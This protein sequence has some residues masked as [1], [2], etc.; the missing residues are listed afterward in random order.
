M[1]LRDIEALCGLF[2]TGDRWC[3][4][5]VSACLCV[6]CVLKLAGG[7]GH[8]T[9]GTVVLGMSGRRTGS[10]FARDRCDREE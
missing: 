5:C 9:P 3:R 2:C 8:T 4:V 10:V 1:S 6:W 7:H